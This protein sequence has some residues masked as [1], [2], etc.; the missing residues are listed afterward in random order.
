[1]LISSLAQPS[2]FESLPYTDKA[3]FN[4][5]QRQHEPVCLQNT[6]VDLLRNIYEW[7]DGQDNG[8]IF[9]LNG[10]AGTGKS[11]IA[12]TVAREYFLKKCLGAS[13]FFVRGG[14]DL[15]HAG[16]FVT[17]VA[18]QLA[19]NI[20]TLHQYIN[21][22]LAE[23]SGIAS[24]SLRDQWHHL[25]LVPL[26][27]LNIHDCQSSYVLVVDALDE[28]DDEMNIRIILQLLTEARSLEKVRLR[29]FLTSRPEIPI[30][31]T[32]RNVPD[33]E[34]QDFVLHNISPS[35]VDHDIQMLLKHD[36]SLLGQKYFLGPDWPGEDR[37]NHLMETASGLF[38]WAATA[39]RFISE[40]KRFAP[41]R[42]DTILK[43]NGSAATAPEKHLDEIYITVLQHS[44]STEYM[45]EEKEVLYYTLRQI[46]GSIVTL[47]SPLCVGSLGRLLHVRKD[48][49]NQTLDD[50]YSVL[51]IPED[52]AIPLRLHHPSFRDFLLS[53]DRCKDLH[54]WVDQKQ[55]HQNLT[56]Y[57]IRLMSTS[58]KKDICSV[59]IPGTLVADVEQRQLEQYLPL[60]VQYA[61]LYWIQHIQ[62]SSEQLQDNGQI[63]QFLLE[64]L[65]HWLEALG[66][67]QKISDGILGVLSLESVAL[68]SAST[69][70]KREIKLN[71]S[72]LGEQMSQ[73]IRVYQRCKAVCITQSGCIRV[74]STTSLLQ[75]ASIFT[76]NESG[77]EAFY[78]SAAT[79]A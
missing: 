37:I 62:K 77:T 8:Y 74:R 32:F 13:F 23:R 41:K 65:L 25:V 53:K 26:L 63:H 2:P 6:R 51:D 15:G 18:V 31:Y 71:H 28:C 10:L 20:P 75:C 64:H 67:M 17:T 58:L 48:E 44:I 5:Y 14:G 59:V 4:A 78:E 43:G 3:S 52:Q 22:A 34:H 29:V 33:T 69:T 73:S 70:W 57:C 16:K 35:I 7:V 49:V 72:I 27:K 56:D 54:F 79:V 9:W 19:R 30:R 55:A 36:L 21:D 68:V 66:W 61:C 11:T 1:V 47:F 42:L 50:L 60:E 40:G 76:V 38:I 45:D 46:L 39:C 12:R 24:Q